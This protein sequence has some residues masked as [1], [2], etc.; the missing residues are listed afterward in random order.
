MKLHSQNPVLIQVLIHKY[1]HIFHSVAYHTGVFKLGFYQ[2]HQRVIAFIHIT[3]RP[4]QPFQRK[5]DRNL[6]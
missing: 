1:S 3:R 4:H 2:P 6:A 5:V